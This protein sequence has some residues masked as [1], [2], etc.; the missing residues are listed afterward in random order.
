[1]LEDADLRMANPMDLD[2]PRCLSSADEAIAVLREEHAR[3]Q[4]RQ[5]MSVTAEHGNGTDG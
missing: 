3:W 1:M 5:S 4:K 2:I